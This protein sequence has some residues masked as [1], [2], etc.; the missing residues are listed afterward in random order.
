VLLILAL[1]LGVAAML[2]TSV[3]M[4]S[5]LNGGYNR[6]TTGF[7]AAESGLNVGMDN[8][9]NKFLLMQL[10]C[11][12]TS[13]TCSDFN[14]TTYSL[15]QRTV[16]YQLTDP[17]GNPTLALVPAGHLF[18]GLYSQQYTYLVDSQSLNNG[19]PEADV[20]AQF[21][22]NDIPLFQFL[23]FYSNDLE[24]MPGPSMTMH[25]RVHTNGDLYLNSDNTLQITTSA[26]V[27]LVQ[28]TAK[29]SIHRGRKDTGAVNGTVQVAT[30]APTPVLQTLAW[31][32]TTSAVVPTSTLATWKGSMVAGV[33]S[34]N[35]P[36]PAILQPNT[37][38]D[39]WT[40]ADL[41]IALVL[42]T[43]NP[44]GPHSIVAL[45][46]DGTVDG[47]PTTGL[48]GTLTSF[49]ND[50]AFNAAKSQFKG[51][52]PIFLSDVPLPTPGPGCNCNLNSFPPT[53]CTA[54][55]NCY[56]GT[57]VLTPTVTPTVT[58]TLRSG[59]PSA[60]RTATF[61]PP[62]Q[63]PTPTPT[64]GNL[65]AFYNLDRT[66]TTHTSI[67]YP[68]VTPG[69]T[70][71]PGATPDLSVGSMF[72]DQDPRRGGFF[73][74]RE[75]QWM[76]LLNV[77]LR[78]LL[79]WNMDRGNAFFDPNYPGP[80]VNDQSHTA[81]G[82]PVIYFT[83]IGPNS[84]TIN[85]YGIRIFGS[86][87]LPFPAPIGA[88]PT[89]ITL[90]SDQAFY[91]AGDYNV[92]GTY[93]IGTNTASYP[94]QPAAFMGDSINVMS[95]VALL[96]TNNV[97]CTNDCQSTLTLALRPASTGTTT[98]NAAFIGGV[99]TTTALIYNGGLENYPRFHESWSNQTLKYTGS[100]VSLG[101][102]A[103]VN[104]H[105]CQVGGT[106]TPPVGYPNTG[107]CNIYDPPI[108]V[109]DYDTDFNNVKN[110]PPMTPFF[111][112]VQQIVFTENFK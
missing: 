102:P 110:L 29:N 49:I 15:G 59:T 108:R 57:P 91:I 95:N 7:Y 62:P 28:I 90:V 47:S 84:N 36:M 34:I 17:G 83:V 104:G 105:W 24:I 86:N 112:Y 75:Q 65:H 55:L 87:P 25:G 88:D 6:A 111:V 77:N 12:G 40:S 58:A 20:G 92:A 69:T 3:T 1:L 32:G 81:K 82:G 56:F 37:N 98:I 94:K 14:P 73:N 13:S 8:F 23:A 38:G 63:S 96:P 109:Y 26:N 48:T 54:Q 27:P 21:I 93:T 74:W 60:T 107:N 19:V 31:I 10:P 46:L 4:D 67:T 42:N 103:H 106:S 99:D 97:A 79:Q 72:K 2:T 52:K 39:Y 70:A 9:R 50:A 5:G 16:S 53:P 68:T 45:K 33:N 11:S 18:A 35:V 30:T 80:S 66:Y 61:T 22:I 71:T 51:T 76:Y 44:Q 78:D 89:G 41:R 85:N 43:T 64:Y 101:N 100:F